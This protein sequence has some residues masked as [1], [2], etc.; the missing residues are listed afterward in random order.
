MKPSA[1]AKTAHA[2]IRTAKIAPPPK[3]GDASFLATTALRIVLREEQPA[4]MTKVLLDLERAQMIA[5]DCRSAAISPHS[6]DTPNSDPDRRLLSW[7]EFGKERDGMCTYLIEEVI[8]PAKHVLQQARGQI[9]RQEQTPDCAR[10]AAR[11]RDA[12]H[13]AI[14]DADEVLWTA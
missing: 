13:K 14:W 7:K 1:M 4:V 2:S 3:A 5:E 10:K 8:E 11:D 12:T 6:N 9:R